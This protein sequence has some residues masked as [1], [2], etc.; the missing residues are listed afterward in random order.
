MDALAPVDHAIHACLPTHPFQRFPNSK[1]IMQMPVLHPYQIY[2]LGAKNMSISHRSRCRIEALLLSTLSLLRSA[3][4]QVSN[5]I[6][7]AQPCFAAFVSYLTLPFFASLSHTCTFCRRLTRI[8]TDKPKPNF[9]GAM[10]RPV[11][12]AWVLCLYRARQARHRG[13]SRR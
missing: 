13:R 3:V 7:L 2:N 1:S 9:A 12:L 11:G 5:S 10:M 6:I 4:T 8:Q